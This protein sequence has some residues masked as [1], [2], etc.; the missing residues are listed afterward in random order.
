MLHAHCA[1][2]LQ[3]RLRLALRI[4]E[5]IPNDRDRDF[6]VEIIS[7]YERM[8]RGSTAGPIEPAESSVA[9]YR[10]ALV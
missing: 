4:I 7:D 3:R 8:C 9:S 6:L 5:A 2:E 10:L 1:A